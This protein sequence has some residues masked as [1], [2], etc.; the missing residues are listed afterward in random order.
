M[1]QAGKVLH[2]YVEVRSAAEE[3]VKLPGDDGTGQLMLQC[4][5]VL[6]RS[7]RSSTH[8]SPNLSPAL[9]PVFKYQIREGNHSVPSSKSSP[10]PS[11]SFQLQNPDATGSPTQVQQKDVLY[12]SFGQLLQVF[13]S[14]KIYSGQHGSL[15][16]TC[17]SEMDPHQGRVLMSPSSTSSGRLTAPSTQTGIHRTYAVPGLENEEGKTSVVTYGYIEKSNVHSVGGRRTSL[18]QSELNN[19]LYRM[20]VQPTPA[21]IQKR[22][23]DPLR[24]SGHPGQGDLYTTHPHP[25]QN[26][27]P[28]GSPFMQRATLD[29]TNREEFGSPEIRRRFAGHSPVNHSQ[30]LQR[31]YQTPRCRSW[32]GSPVL[33]RG[34]F[35]LPPKTQLLDLDRGNCRSSVNGLPRSPASDH[36][37]AHTGHSFHTWGPASVL[38]SHGPPQSQQRTRAMDESPRLSSKFHPPL[39]AGRPTDI[40]HDISTSVH[41][42]SNRYRTAYQASGSPQHCVNSSYSSNI[43]NSNHN[44]IDSVHYNA[45]DNVSSKTFYNSSRCSSRASDSVSPTSSRKSIYPSSNAEMACKLAVEASKLSTV[46]ADRRTPSPALSQAESLRSESPKTGGSF[47]RETQP[48][49]TLH[50]RRSPEHLQVDRHN[51]KT[52]LPQ[53]RPGRISPVLNQKVLSSSALPA[54]LQHAGTSQSPVLD[55]R[56]Q[57][58]P[59]ANKDLSTLHRYQPPQ[60]MGDRKLPVTEL[61]QCDHL[62]YR[63]SRDS[64]EVSRRILSSQN[65]EL[66]VSWTSMHQEWRD[67]GPV[68]HGS[69]LCENSYKQS[70]FRVYRKVEG[71]KEIK[72]QR[73]QTPIISVSNDQREEVQ[74][75]SGVVGTSCQSSSGVTGS[76]EDS[77]QMDRN[78]GLSPETLSLSSHDTADTGSGM[79]VGWVGG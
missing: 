65:T 33:P 39:P 53:T 6:P 34:T 2:L 43:T 13:A 28:W 9:S 15:G 20:E 75:N 49:A 40:Q 22:L 35:T 30:T 46:F 71:D 11:V 59:S 10:R 66:P 44:A 62:F 63:S 77:S 54:Q 64:P 52:T 79:Q 23:S 68:Q 41:P 32:A 27:F 76:M 8:S 57:R 31:N 56:Q 12:D 51:H 17:S 42:F 55:L 70:N 47:L 25:F 45:N 61:R 18:G 1:S 58:S 78:D 21:H 36:L 3:E 5:D 73:Y 50:G 4:P 74:D 69:G 72:M 19:P 67:A 48:Y 29:V 24:Y 60:Y 7:Q 14:E 26:R 37:C 16:Q 38:H